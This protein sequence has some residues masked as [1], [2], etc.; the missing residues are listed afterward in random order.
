MSSSNVP[1]V[2]G[3]NHLSFTVANIEATLAF[4]CEVLGAELL[5]LS[6]AANPTGVRLLTG[7]PEAEVRFAFLG[8]GM[9]RIELVE[10]SS[11]ADR[12]TFLPRPCDTGFAHL[13]LNV[14]NVPMLIA[15][16]AHYQFHPIGET[17]EMLGGV[18]KGKT[19]TY[20][21]GTDGLTLELIGP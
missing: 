9:Q 12:Q 21:R 7:V 16:A 5:S 14:T 10:Y 6:K 18:D 2:T 17:I 4:F 11:P 1:A 8:F 20:L 3:I 19:A 15:K 13:A